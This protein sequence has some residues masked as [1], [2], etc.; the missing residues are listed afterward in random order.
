MYK[1]SKIPAFNQFDRDIIGEYSLVMNPLVLSLDKL[2][3]E[4]DAYMG[5]PLSSLFGLR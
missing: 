4:S 2:Q 5:V 3:A 1:E